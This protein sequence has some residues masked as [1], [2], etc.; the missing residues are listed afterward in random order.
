MSKEWSQGTHCLWFSYPVHNNEG[1]ELP[2]QR[3][4]KACATEAAQLN[5]WADSG[6]QKEVEINFFI[7]QG[8]ENAG[9]SSFV[10]CN[11]C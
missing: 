11:F 1:K 6:G 3:I 2:D 4:W 8:G 9:V 10:W 5:P 7:K